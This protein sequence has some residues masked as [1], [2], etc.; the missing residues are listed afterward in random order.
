M[1]DTNNKQIKKLKLINGF[2]DLS[3]IPKDEFDFLI[4]GLKNSIYKYY[5]E[6]ENKKT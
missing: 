6:L 4:V 2:I 1:N 3:K 5:K